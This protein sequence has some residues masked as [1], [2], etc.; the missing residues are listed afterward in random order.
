MRLS[1]GDL[2]DGA[3]AFALSAVGKT[4]PLVR[5]RID[6]IAGTDIGELAKVRADLAK[7]A[8]NLV[9]PLKIVDAVEAACTLSFDE[10]LVRERQLFAECMA[11][12]QSRGLIHAFF[13]EREASKIPDI[14]DA[15][16]T[17][18]IKQVAIIGAGTMGGGIAMNFANA[19]IP[20]ALIEVDNAALERGIERIR[21]NYAGTV[22]KGRLTEAAMNER[23]S[24]LQPTTDFA[25]VADADLIIEAAFERMDVKLDIFR[26]LDKL[27]KP[28]AILATNTSSLD[29]DEIAAATSRPADVLGLHFFSPANVMRLLEVVRGRATARDVLATVMAVSRKIKK[30]AVVVGVCDGFVGNRML[31]P[32]AREAEFLVAEGATPGEVDAALLQ[33]GMAM[34]PFAMLDMAGLDV[35]SGGAPSNAPTGARRAARHSQIIEHLV[36]A[37]RYGQKTG[38]GWYRYEPGKRVPLPDP[39]IEHFFAEEAQRLGIE[40][41]PISADEIVNRCLYAL[42]NEGAKILDEGMALRGDD[43]DVIYVSGYGFPAF[44]GG[45]MFWADTVG[46]TNILAD[47]ERFHK[48]HGDFWK[49]SPCW[50]ASPRRASR[51]PLIRRG[52]PPDR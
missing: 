23:M 21:G 49:P 20:V 25:R 33:F 28:G 43:I 35:H 9:S 51:W 50:F 26:R 37:G 13:A 24:R 31:A 16:P 2:I 34:G 19:G 27:A 18:S 17:R 39:S 8:R 14:P 6:K 5:D 12:P 38:A 52:M 48:A 22:S 36:E 29:V 46:L 4:A 40:R 42:V 45:P 7:K 44:R 3:A 15:T 11:S 1:Q 41:R 32:Y 47:I 30:I 10:G